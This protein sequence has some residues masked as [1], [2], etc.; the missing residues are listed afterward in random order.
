MTKQETSFAL[1]AR[2]VSLA[3]GIVGLVGGS[4][5]IVSFYSHPEE[6]RVSTALDISRSYLRETGRDTI[7]MFNEIEGSQEIRPDLRGPIAEFGDYAEYISLL[8]NENK[9]A[10][11]YLSPALVCAIEI[12]A[13]A[14]KRYKLTIP[15]GGKEMLKFANVHPC[16]RS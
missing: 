12:T 14:T 6:I 2:W 10:V 1:A 8:A 5:G 16:P 4:L 15:N 9:L 13:N 7:K 11:N 3:G